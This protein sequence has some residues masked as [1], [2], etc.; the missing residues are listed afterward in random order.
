MN[1]EIRSMPKTRASLLAAIA[2]LAMLVVLVTAASATAAQSPWWQVTDGSRP[3]HLWAPEPSVRELETELKEVPGVEPFAVIEIKVNGSTVGCLG[4]KNEIGV[5]VCTFGVGFPPIE[6]AA[7]LQALLE[8]ALGNSE[9][10]VTGGPLGGEPFEIRAPGATAP[11]GFEPF[12]E[13]GSATLKTIKPGGSGRLLMT[14]TNLGNAAVDGTETPVSIVDELPE[15]VI[16]TGVEAGA[17]VSNLS[18]HV[19]CAVNSGDLVTCT[20]DG[21]LPPYEA[22]EVEVLASLTGDPPAAGAPGKITV[23]GGNAPEA[24][25][26]Q[27]IQV[28]P[29]PV[30]FGIERFS[31]AAE[32]E[33]GTIAGQA[34]SHPYQL[35]TTIQLNAGRLIQGA[36]KDGDPRKGNSVEQPALPRNLRFPLPAGLVGNAS[37]MPT[38]RVAAFVQIEPQDGCSPESAV[39]VAVVNLSDAFYGY[40]RVPVPVFNLPPTYGEPARFGFTALSVPVTIDTKVDPGNGYRV[41]ASVSN[42]TQLAPFYASTVVLWG[43]PGD[44]SHDLAR[45]WNC[46]TRLPYQGLGPCVRPSPLSEVAFLRQPVSCHDSPGFEVAVEPWNVPLGTE[47]DE[48]FHPGTSLHGCNKVPFDPKVGA[49]P[50]SR[51]AESPTGLDFRLDMPNSGLA[52]GDAIAEGQAKK[53]EVTLPEGMTINPSQAEGLGVCSPAEYAREQSDSAPGA[54]CPD[55]SKI[56]EIQIS[57]PLLKEEAHGALYVAKPYDNPGNSL[58][59]LYLV[60]RIPERG[61]LVTQFGKVTPD[62]KTGQLVTTFDGLPQLPFSSFKLHFREG[63]RAPL[64]TPPSC[65][66]F[67]VVARF[68]PWSASD[69]DNPLPQEIVTR[70]SSATIERGPDGGACPSGGTPFRPGFEAGSVNPAA[71][72]YS[73]F[74]MRITRKDGDQDL[75]KFSAVL[76]EGALAKLAGVTRCP[77]A[78]VEAAKRKQGLEEKASPSCPAS[79]RIGRTSV[80]AGVGSILTYVPGQ[81]YL[82]GPYHGST[83]SVVSITPAVAGPFDLGTVVV[84]EGLKLDPATGEVHVDGNASDPIPHILQ[85]VPLKVR[86]LRVYVDRDNFTTTPTSCDPM[87]TKAVLF[88]SG[89]DVFSSGDDVQADLSARYQAAACES[90]GFKPR[91][92]LR[93]SGKRST[94]GA[95]PALHAVLRPRLGD[96]NPDQIQVALPGSELLEQSHIRTICTRVQFAAGAGFGSNCP[97]GSVYGHVKAWTPLLDEPLEGPVYLR[98]SN[99]E[100]PDMVLALS[101]LVNIESVGRIDSKN[102]RIR[103]TFENVPDAPL[104]KVVL[105]MQGGRKGLLVNSTDICRGVHRAKAVFI[106]QNGKRYTTTPKVAA[107]CGKKKRGKK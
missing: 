11:I 56:G 68:T 29:E 69:P 6:T 62:P 14:M 90:L 8:T 81:L 21:T 32:A 74:Y 75:T 102:G 83:L 38:C 44:P 70:T 98:S 72:R 78:A 80:G 7:E 55:A 96:A 106:G 26:A 28:S 93:L 65:G 19:D 4:T 40:V 33:G 43:D 20:F 9:V 49:S 76:P 104:T 37:S 73:P 1:Q 47:I 34:G 105:D 77:Q 16:A 31:A 22:I 48:A 89:L 13:A 67:D 41:V 94:R 100:L 86:D 63:G 54:G 51:L 25:A 39:G 17:G 57:T 3:S 107:K 50:T 82:G 2:S 5:P 15:G 91:V 42:V 59:G 64:V 35:T 53:V 45:G 30:P 52:D 23:S 99:H 24:S 18:G 27:T 61:I 58:I 101:G 10:E 95:N 92:Q 66:S 97:Q 87:A 46:T 79:S 71:G 88:G 12:F 103:S 60:A 84:Q 85:G 36:G